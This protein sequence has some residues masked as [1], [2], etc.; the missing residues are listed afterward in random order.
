M[1]PSNWFIEFVFLKTFASCSFSCDFRSYPLSPACLNEVTVA[2][3]A[4]N[5]KLLDIHA[6]LSPALKLLADKHSRRLVH[7][8]L[9]NQTEASEHSP[10]LVKKRNREAGPL[11]SEKKFMEKINFVSTRMVG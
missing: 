4:L 5:E 8:N 3:A 7:L 1:C 10:P 2:E 11:L 6:D 9:K